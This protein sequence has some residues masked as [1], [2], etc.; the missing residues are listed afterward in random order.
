MTDLIP[1][2][3]T[4]VRSGNIVPAPA[5]SHNRLEW[6][7]K[8]S[9]EV[10]LAGQ[11][12]SGALIASPT[13]R[14]YRYAWLRDGA[15]CANAL[16]RTG[17]KDAAADFF[18]WIGRVLAGYSSKVERAISLHRAGE[19]LSDADF[20]NTRYTLDGQE[21][22]PGADGENW[23]NF[24]LDGYGTWLW[25]L[26]EHL[27]RYSN[28]NLR[29]E[30][31]PA[32]E[33][34]ARYLSAFW[35]LPNFDCW[36]ENRQ[37]VH[38]ATL[39]AIYGGLNSAARLYPESKICR[40][41]LR[42]SV[43]IRKYVKQF[44]LSDG[45][46]AKSVGR[47]DVDA[48]LLGAVVPYKLFA[49]GSLV[50][51]HTLARISQQLLAPD[52]GVYRYLKDV[53]YG[54]GEWL[55]LTGWLGWYYAETRQS[56]KA[57]NCLHWVASQ[58]DEQG[59]MPEQAAHHLLSPAHLPEWNARWGLSAKPLLWSHAMYLILYTALYPVG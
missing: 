17:H 56:A 16:D 48:S 46:L 24:Q 2:P 59:E 43:T 52:G 42:Q 18:R 11:S 8:R 7:A 20:L 38:P 3:I 14:V 58:A 47:S 27:K 51:R 49:P 37:D 9:Q 13:F 44:G 53:Y 55:L 45:A 41:G 30:L 23:W 19:P 57:L 29:A 22:E 33:L 5:V 4:L 50:M 40:A 21:E 12:P 35:Q 34:T 10:L 28:E 15:F 6:L 32:V 25:A 36:E 26:E 1:R 39:A 31:A 54:G